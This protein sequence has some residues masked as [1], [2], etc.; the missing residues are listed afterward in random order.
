[1]N[2]LITITFSDG[3]TEKYPSGITYLE[4]SKYYQQKH[5]TLILGAKV[6][7]VIKNMS[8][9]VYKDEE[10]SF[11]DFNDIDGHRMYISG[12]KFITI[13]A[14]KELWGENTEIYFLNSI[15]KG[16]YTKIETSLNITE[17]ELLMLSDKIKEVVDLDLSFDKSIVNKKEVISYYNQIGEPE[18]ANNINRIPNS[19]VKLY[20]LKNLYNYFYTEMPQSTKCLSMFDVTYIKDNYF[21]LRYPGINTNNLIPSYN[22]C[23][24]TLDIFENYRSWLGLVNVKYVSDLNDIVCNNKI[25]DFI[26][27]NKIIV[28]EQIK[29]IVYN[30]VTSKNKIKIVLLAGPSSSGKTTSSKKISLYLKAYGINSIVLSSD[31]Y[32]IDS[33]KT[34]VD[35]DGL[36]EYEKLEA[37]EIDMLNK[38]INSLLNHE[39][40]VLPEYNF[41]TGKKEFKNLPKKLN[42]EDVIILEGLHCLNDAITLGIERE[43]KYKI[44]ISPFTSLSIDRHN[45]ISN[46]DLRFV[47]RLVRDSVFRGSSVEN[48]FRMWKK[49]V[50][51][52][53]NLI[54]KYQNEADSILNT[55]SIYEIGVL[56]VFAEPLLYS[57]NPDSEFYEESR[58]ILG[59]LRV[60]FT[61]SPELVPHDLVLREFIG[62]SIFL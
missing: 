35:K 58:R 54:Y 24:K 23:Q 28:E 48:T 49:V 52:E 21:V 13:L 57:I 61:I 34:P 25:K 41:I 16:I 59:F 4:L 55:A 3:T 44:Y 62:G 37:L 9:K 14:A 32:F 10:I 15:D 36:K 38:D 42:D 6:N 51:D 27:Q 56:K 22:N 31:D 19:I 43:N 46:V 33:D 7:N 8:E 5:K 47:R 39:E 29:N 17:K 2:Q 53:S 45:H 30:I 11:F 20:K 1:M 40:V 18:K 60:F 26:L 12:L 50:E